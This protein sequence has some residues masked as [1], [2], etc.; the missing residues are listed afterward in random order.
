MCLAVVN[1]FAVVCL[2]IDARVSGT[3]IRNKCLETL[4]IPF[5]TIA[6]S[7]CFSKLLIKY[8]EFVF[9]GLTSCVLMFI[10]VWW[11]ILKFS[12]S[13]N[14]RGRNIPPCPKQEP[15]TLIWFL[16]KWPVPHRRHISVEDWKVNLSANAFTKVGPGET[17]RKCDPGTKRQ[18][19]IAPWQH[20]SIWDLLF[21]FREQ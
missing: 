6:I 11:T 5:D 19:K 7:G 13:Q 18:R 2:C 20:E 21:L 4:K 9:H 3:R 8:N 10:T 14:T 16:K 15:S 12:D 1:G 17:G